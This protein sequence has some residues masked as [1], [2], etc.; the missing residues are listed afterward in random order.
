[1]KWG[2]SI[3]AKTVISLY[4]GELHSEDPDTCDSAYKMQLGIPERGGTR[5]VTAKV[6]VDATDPKKTRICALFNHSCDPDADFSVKS[7]GGFWVSAVET[8]RA[9]PGGKEITVDYGKCNHVSF[10]CKC[11][12][13]QKN[14]S[15]TPQ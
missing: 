2:E 13:C 8:K 7:C 6:W 1:M 12:V 10:K 9:I 14:A 11:D 15:G 4:Y 5:T 3:P